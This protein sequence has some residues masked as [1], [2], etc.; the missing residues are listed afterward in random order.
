MDK[1]K[2]MVAIDESE[3]SHYALQWALENLGDAISKSDLIIFTAR[4]TE[5][6]YV[7]ASMFGAAPPDLLMSI[8]ENQKKA[9]L[10]L[11]GRAKEICAKH[12]VVAETMTE[13]GDPKNVICEAAE[14]HKIQLLIVGSHSRGPIQRAFLGSVSNYCVHNAKCPVLVHLFWNHLSIRVLQ[15]EKKIAEVIVAAEPAEGVGERKV[16]VAIDESEQSHYALMWVLD[17]LKESISKFPLI[18]FMA[19]PPTKSEFVF[20][21]P[22]GYARL[23]SSALTTQGF[24][25]SAEEKQRKLTLAFLQKLKDILS[26]QGVKAE[27]IV[28]VWDPTMAI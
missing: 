16:M 14:K 15:P 25:N 2:V 18:I 3:C 13:M 12:G 6:I 24:V 10:A 5:F 20:T 28:E 17:N 1:K 23:Y 26:S 22:F 8:Q 9:A 21:A 7:Q 19:Q 27:M 4:P 11:L